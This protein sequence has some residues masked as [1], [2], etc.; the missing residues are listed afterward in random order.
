MIF[1]TANEKDK[2]VEEMDHVSLRRLRSII[3]NLLQSN[4]FPSNGIQPSLPRFT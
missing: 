4:P 1:E 3:R 2:S